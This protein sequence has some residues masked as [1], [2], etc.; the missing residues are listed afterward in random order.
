MGNYVFTAEEVAHYGKEVFDLIENN[1]LKIRIFK[2]YSFTA[3]DVQNAQRD[4]TSGKTTGK[5]LIKVGGSFDH[6][7]IY[8]IILLTLFKGLGD[9][10]NLPLRYPPFW[11]D[12]GVCGSKK[13]KKKKRRKTHYRYMFL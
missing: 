4:L 12:G 11:L 3:E 6:C 9:N 10:K 2:E 1:E 13:K 8:P 7:S 5:L